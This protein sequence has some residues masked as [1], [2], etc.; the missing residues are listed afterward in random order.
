MNG[1][2]I[3]LKAAVWVDGVIAS[4]SCIRN[5]RSGCLMWQYQGRPVLLDAAKNSH[6]A[7][8]ILK[9]QYGESLLICV[10]TGADQQ[11]VE[12]CCSSVSDGDFG[13][14]SDGGVVPV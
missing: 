9:K 1:K 3:E 14:A 12:E 4:L 11:I 6:D 13:D 2:N 10:E 8:L 7:E 5:K